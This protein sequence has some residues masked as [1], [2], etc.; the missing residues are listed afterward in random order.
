MKTLIIFFFFTLLLSCQ[1]DLEPEEESF[2][3]N[4]TSIAESGQRE[5]GDP[6]A[7]LEY[8]IYGD[9]ISSGFPYSFFVEN[10]PLDEANPLARIGINAQ[11]PFSFNAVKAS[12]GVDIVA[13]NCLQ[14]HAQY[15]DGEFILG[16]GN[17]DSDYTADQSFALTFSDLAIENAFGKT[18]LEWEAYEPFSRATKTSAPH[19][20][21][22]VKGVNP[23]D[24][25][26]AVLAAHRDPTSLRW[27]DNPQYEIPDG[28]IPTDVPPLWLMKKKNALY[29]TGSGRGDQARLMTIAEILTMPDTSKASQVDERFT[30][31]Y[32]FL[33]NLEPPAYP[34]SIDESKAEEGRLLF[35][36]HCA[37]CHGSDAYPNLL[38]DLDYI[39]TDPELAKANFAYV[40]FLDWYNNSWYSTGSN[41]ASFEKTEGYIAPPLDGIWATAPYLHN[42]SVPD[43]ES[44]LDS[45]SRPSYWKRVDAY[46]YENIGWNYTSFSAGAGSSIYDT[47]KKGY[48]NMGHRFGDVLNNEER[49][50]VIEYLKTL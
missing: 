10:F 50:Q 7:G 42:G 38:V 1:V 48:G 41:S 29:Y 24:K 2:A 13:P 22:E 21:T 19:L 28:L 37:K 49:A 36:D 9:Y 8:M 39:G 27:L 20:V 15:L 30:D 14:C 11:I 3:E 26:T 43:L 16:L 4:V 5:L 25:L 31:V 18:S 34:R 46:N 40:D 23:A 6:N 45:E 35:K 33:K 12:N 44:L 32:T 47:S 17:Y